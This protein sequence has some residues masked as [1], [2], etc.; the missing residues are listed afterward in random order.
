MT[1]L[2]LSV[3]DF[4]AT[5]SKKEEGNSYTVLT[6]AKLIEAVDRLWANRIPGAGEANLDRK[7]LVPITG[8]FLHDFGKPLFFCP[9]RV[10]LVVGMPVQ[11]H[12][13]ARQDGEE[14]YVETFVT[15]DVAEKYGYN[16][17]PAKDVKVVVYS[18]AALMENGGNPTTNAD[19]EIVTLLCSSGEQEPMMPLA[20]ARNMLEKAGGTKGDYTAKDFAEAVWYWS[21][22][23]GLKVRAAK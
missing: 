12:V 7:V 8:D 21:T 14:P 15:P 20:M 6:N 17:T 11:A 23:R 3:N 1:D 16:E 4:Y 19:W 22:K 10:N 13:V 18:R 2:I 5:H 9:P